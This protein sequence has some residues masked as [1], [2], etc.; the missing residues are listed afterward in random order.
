MVPELVPGPE[1]PQAARAAPAPAAAVKLRK[2]RRDI[3]LRSTLVS[4]LVSRRLAAGSN[5]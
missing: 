1:L 2:V 3:G 5:F 4:V